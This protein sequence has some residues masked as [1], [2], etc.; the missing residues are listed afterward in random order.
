M[1]YENILVATENSIATITI[2]RPTKLNALNRKTIEELHQPKFRK[3]YD[4]RV[5]I[6]TGSGEKLCCRCRY[7]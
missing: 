7:I 4:T 1:N 5:I 3:N 6:L 2:N